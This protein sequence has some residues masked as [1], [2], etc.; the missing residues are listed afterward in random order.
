MLPLGASSNQPSNV[1]SRARGA[2]WLPRVHPDDH[3][4]IEA[5]IAN[6]Q[7]VA[8]QW[9]IH[10]TSARTGNP[11]DVRAADFFQVRDGRLSELRR[12]LDFRSLNRQAR[13]RASQA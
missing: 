11:I 9:R 6:D 3:W 2:W 4:A 13:R 10:A 8:C 1:S 5:L 12:Y 7:V